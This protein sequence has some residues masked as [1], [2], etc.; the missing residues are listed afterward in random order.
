MKLKRLASLLLC[1]VSILAISIPS[2]SAIES[3]NNN[4]SILLEMGIP[5]EIIEVIP[6][7]DKIKFHERFC[8][9]RP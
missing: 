6:N 5:Y 1:T 4:N 3:K 2:A 7:T 9:F 8:N